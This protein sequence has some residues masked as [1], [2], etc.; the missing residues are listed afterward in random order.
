[1]CIRDRCNNI[2][3]LIFILSNSFY[4]FLFYYVFILFSPNVAKYIIPEII[5]IIGPVGML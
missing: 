2:V 3:A 4:E 1:M 5:T